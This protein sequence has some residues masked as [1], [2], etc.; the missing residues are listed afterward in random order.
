MGTILC[1]ILSMI[2]PALYG[3]VS[4]EG[5]DRLWVPFLLV[6]AGGV[7]LC[8][9][10]LTSGMVP[11]TGA[12]DDRDYYD[13]SIRTFRG[14]GDWFDLTQFRDTHE[15]A[16]Y[17]MMLAWVNQLA[18]DSLLARKSLNVSL[19]LTLSVIWFV[20]G[21][22]I[23]GHRLARVCLIGVLLCTPLWF[24]WVFLL[25]D[26]AIVVLQSC[27]ILGAVCI[28]ENE[29]AYRGYWL[30]A[31]STVAIIP[32][33]SALALVNVALL[34]LA[35]VLLPRVVKSRARV[36]GRVI[37]LACLAVAIV[38]VVAQPKVVGD[39][40]ATGATRALDKEGLRDTLAFY[41]AMRPAYFANVLKFVLVYFVGEVAAFNPRTWS[42][43][44]VGAFRAALVVP[45]VYMGLPF[46]VAGATYVMKSRRSGR[47]SPTNVL[48]VGMSIVGQEPRG[49]G[50]PPQD[51]DT[52]RYSSVPARSRND[53][54]SNLNRS[55]L[56]LLA[57]YVLIYMMVAWASGDTTRWR[58]A[59]F[60]PMVAIAG[61][62]WLRASVS[63]RVE[64][65]IFWT[66]SLSLVAIV[67]YALIK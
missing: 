32:L 13:A 3:R 51:A 34:A 23:G 65:L 66:M 16:G 37:A 18:G 17:P 19:F 24:Y 39:F 38:L 60:P 47:H 12:G 45:W 6:C 14:I 29:R 61:V 63:R 54:T 44:L 22:R 4:A 35:I 59:S 40:G 67:Y 43:E 52:L 55:Y 53:V 1:L 50:R 25:K 56:L 46:F 33:R 48:P 64:V 5:V 41:D 30:V 10:W 36:L 27:C 31:L 21:R 20:I 28:L 57:G 58:M 26:M 15:Q 2:L 42:G 11:F 8:M 7:F 49:P 62:G 9:A